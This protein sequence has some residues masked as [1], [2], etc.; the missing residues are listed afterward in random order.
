MKGEIIDNDASNRTERTRPYK[1]GVALSILGAMLSML[2]ELHPFIVSLWLSYVVCSSI[3]FITNIYWKIS[4]H[5]IGISIPFAVLMF[6][7]GNI[8]FYFLIPVILVSWSRVYQKLHSLSQ[9]LV[10]LVI[11]FI[12][13]NLILNWSLRLL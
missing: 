8:G 10:G 11:G 4:A 2:F 9:V 1:I 3:L 6:M 13:T 7:L 12:I 5:A